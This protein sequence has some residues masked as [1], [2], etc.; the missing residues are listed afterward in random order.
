MRARGAIKPFIGAVRVLCRFEII[1]PVRLLGVRLD[2]A[3]V[4]PV[5]PEA[6]STQQVPGR[7]C[8]RGIRAR[9]GFPVRPRAA[10]RWAREESRR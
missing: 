4:G 2:L 3:P 9:R 6:R 1:R 10:L 8:C 7:R 5:L